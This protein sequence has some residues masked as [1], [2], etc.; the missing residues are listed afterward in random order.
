MV[1]RRVQLSILFSKIMYRH[2][3]SVVRFSVLSGS[4]VSCVPN[5][6]GATYEPWVDASRQGWLQIEFP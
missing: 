1:S 2:V 5:K 3:D 6:S 4:G